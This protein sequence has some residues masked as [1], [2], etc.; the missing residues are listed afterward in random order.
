MKLL[1]SSTVPSAG[2]ADDDSKRFNATD[3]ATGE[4]L[5]PGFAEGTPGEV[6]RLV[7]AAA[8]A[9]DAYR[10][11]TPAERA[12]FLRAIAEEILALDTMLLARAGSETG[13]PEARLTGERGRTV[14]Q[15][16]LFAEVLEEGSWVGAR[17]D[18]ALPDRAPLPRPDLRRMLVPIGP[19]AVFGASNFPLAFSVAG[20][21]TAS[22][23]AAGCPVVF[24]AHQA[25]PGTSEMTARAVIRAAERTGMPEGVFS[26]IQGAGHEVGLALVRHP[27]IRAVGF[28]GSL[29]G[30][31]ALF[32]AAAARPDPIPV[33]AEMG[34]VNPVFLLDSA[35]AGDRDA[36]AAGLANSVTMGVGQF[37]TNPGVVVA[38][39]GSNLRDLTE[40]LAERIRAVAP[41]PMLYG[42]ICEQYGK[43]VAAL[44]TDPD[45]KVLA[46]ADAA[47]DAERFGRAAVFVTSARAF[48][49]REELRHEVFG[50]SSLVVEAEDDAEM[51]QVAH[52]L[53]GQL[54]GTIHGAPE[55][56]ARHAELVDALQQ[57][58]GR[59]IFNGFPTGV[60]VS[61]AMQH[62]GPYPATTDASSTSVGTAAIG[63]FVRPVTYQDFPDAIL[64]PEL[65]NAN[66]RGIWRLVDGE[67][68]REAIAG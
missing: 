35:L 7:A 63:R 36:L 3:P 56:L 33:Y 54:T 55:E 44:R 42:G 6:D 12:A 24:K 53:E 5:E 45:V 46:E 52:A 21:D 17:I 67:M 30:G 40:R 47:G 58:V 38:R 4:V 41:A 22:A 15:L 14:G 23:L 57:R 8:A 31:R 49:A 32:D 65:R 1:G 9:F 26:L 62:G 68:T 2:A 10:A 60:E 43:Q 29:R 27:A 34:S 28:T 19:V 48:C 39:S 13:L 51:L 64:P 59:L 25:H 50:P 16:R 66:E 18:T 37:C 61:H 11:T 20:G